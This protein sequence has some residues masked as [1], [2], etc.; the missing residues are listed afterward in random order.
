MAEINLPA[1][2][3]TADEEAE[4]LAAI[5]SNRQ[6]KNREEGGNAASM[7]G[8][9]GGTIAAG[10]NPMGGVAGANMA[11]NVSDAGFDVAEEDYGSAFQRVGGMFPSPF[12]DEEADKKKKLKLPASRLK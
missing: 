6:S 5:A 12:G 3:K 2:D 1:P 9:V 11:R 4:R 7:L 10:G 8:F